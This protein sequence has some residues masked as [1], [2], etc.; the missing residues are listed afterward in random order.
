MQAIEALN[1]FEPVACQNQ[2]AKA[3]QPRQ[4]VNLR[5]IIIRQVKFH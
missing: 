2:L 1:R 4:T 3:S 5:D